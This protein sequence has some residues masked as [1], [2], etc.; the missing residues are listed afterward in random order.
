WLSGSQIENIA[1]C[2]SFIVR[3]RPTVGTSITGDIQLPPSFSTAATASSSLGT[4]TYI[5]QCG[6]TF[7]PLG[8]V[9]T[10]PMGAPSGRVHMSYGSG[11]PSN[12]VVVHPTTGL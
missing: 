7:M 11:L 4:P 8:N 6:G 5:P 12:G 3:I 1:P 9:M 10:P 2:G